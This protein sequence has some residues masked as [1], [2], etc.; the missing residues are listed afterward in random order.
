MVPVVRALYMAVH[1]DFQGAG[2][3]TELSAQFLRNVEGSLFRPR[4]VILEVYAE[5][6][7]AKKFMDVGYIPLESRPDIPRGLDEEKEL[8]VMALDI[9]R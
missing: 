1:S 6:P 9:D 5:N 7:M 2:F 4:F 3:S 8:I